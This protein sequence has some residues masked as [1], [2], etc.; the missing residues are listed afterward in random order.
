MSSPTSSPDS[1]RIGVRYVSDAVKCDHRTLERLYTTLADEVSPND[2]PRQH[3]LQQRFCWELARHL[4]AMNLFIFPGTTRRASQGNQNAMGRQKDFAILRDKLL[5]FHAVRDLAAPAFRAALV[6]LKED[7]AR[8]IKDVER[9]DMVAIEK[10]LSGEESE[11]LASDFGATAFFVP[12]EV[13][14]RPE[15]KEHIRGPFESIRDLLDASVSDLMVALEGF[16][17]D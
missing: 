5:A 2:A 12:P 13:R 16:P 14:V 11:R 7:L 10:V 1:K 6:Q 17:R 15:G 9:T 8:H 4:V 3:E